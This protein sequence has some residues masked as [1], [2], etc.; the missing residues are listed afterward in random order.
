MIIDSI[1]TQ[2]RR[3]AFSQAPCGI[4]GEGPHHP[5]HMRCVKFKKRIEAGIR[6]KRFQVTVAESRKEQALMA[7]VAKST[8][9]FAG[10]RR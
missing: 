7:L 6:D 8:T 1:T 2:E 10:R 9:K 5:G 4:F 3:A